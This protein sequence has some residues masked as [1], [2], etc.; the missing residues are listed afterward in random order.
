MAKDDT[1]LSVFEDAYYAICELHGWDHIDLGES[2]EKS[3]VQE[4]VIEML[5]GVRPMA[6]SEAQI[7]APHLQQWRA[8]DGQAVRTFVQKITGS[9][10]G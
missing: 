5:Q 2:G 8:L 3:A 9:A 4:E 10:R 6:R 7:L 1:P